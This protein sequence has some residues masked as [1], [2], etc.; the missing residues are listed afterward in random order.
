MLQLRRSTKL[1]ANPERIPSLQLLVLLLLARGSRHLFKSLGQSDYHRLLRDVF[2]DVARS[3]DSL[4]LRYYGDLP[5]EVILHQ[6]YRALI[7]PYDYDPSQGLRGGPYDPIL[8]RLF[9]K[10]ENL[11][12]R[13]NSLEKRL[14]ASTAGIEERFEK[15]DQTLLRL[16]ER[17]LSSDWSLSLGAA[18]GTTRTYRTAPIRIYTRQE[19]PEKTQDT[20][21]AAL[22]DILSD[23]GFDIDLDLPAEKSSF[24]KRFWV[25]TK[26]VATHKE[27]E[28]RFYKLE[29]ALETKHLD[30]PQAEAN[31][32]NAESF[33]AIMQSLADVDDACVQLGNILLVKNTP[34]GDGSKAARVVVR[35]LSALEMHAIEQNQ[36]LLKEPA[37]II[38][39]LETLCLTGCKKPRL[40]HPGGA[41]R[42]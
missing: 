5:V 11:D 7:E 4:D 41:G 35:T 29:R 1:V 2:D 32:M 14:E 9:D 39:E 28:E 38:R 16:A 24:W 30:K 23:C 37:T 27:V 34:I 12:N 36:T 13:S 6:A 10:T 40:E 18:F 8:T 19:L 26:N 42:R 33:S 25:R 15:V 20:L 22:I 17:Q 3:F 31:K 21:H